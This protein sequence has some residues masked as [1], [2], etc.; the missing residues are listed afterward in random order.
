MN[1]TQIKINNKEYPLRFGMG[2]FRYLHGKDLHDLNEIAVSHII[3][4]GYVNHC[5]VEEMERELKFSD[6]VGFVEDCLQGDLEP[7][8]AIMRVWNDNKIIKET[9]DEPKKKPP[10]RK[11]KS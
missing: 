2:S 10:L 6:V 9:A 5:E 7:V 11:L 8:N 3:Y 4:S 1:K